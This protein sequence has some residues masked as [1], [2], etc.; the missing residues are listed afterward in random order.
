MLVAIAL[1]VLAL[2]GHAAL[3]VG[4]VNR[5]HAIGASRRLIDLVT[6]S[7]RLVLIGLP[8]L[9]IG[10]W[11]FSGKPIETWLSS[12]LDDRALRFYLAPCWI[13]ALATIW[14][15][16]E[17]RF[18]A[19]RG[20]AVETNHTEV[21]DVAARLGRKPV[22]GFRAS[23]LSRVPGN[24]VFQLAVRETQLRLPRL[25]KELDGLS[26]AHFSDLHVTGRIEIDYFHEVV[27]RV[28]ALRA[29]LIAVTGDVMDE[30]KHIDWLEETLGRLTAPLG[31]Y[32]VLGNHDQFTGRAAVVR[33]ALVEA[34]LTDLGGRWQRVEAAGATV[35]LAGSELPWLR[36]RAEMEQCPPRQEGHPHLRMLL[37]H[38]PDQF[39]WARRRDFD[40]VL[41]GHTHGGQIC[42][43]LIGP[44]HCPSW[45]GVKY[46][47]GVFF[48]SPTAMHVSR[49]VS[50]ALPIRLNC[51]PEVTKLVLRR[52]F[53]RQWTP[54][55]Q[56]I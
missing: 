9:A 53:N 46:A 8:L 16:I 32:F 54:I 6:G 25:P 52:Q 14:L 38:S 11:W 48:E 27:D 42:F 22:S 17:R 31:A 24:Q 36:L 26:I 47:S 15:W 19:R 7:C 41:A 13:V 21:V 18:D 30:M 50:S 43:P 45:H 35:I 28:L 3:W 1:A 49:G 5:I 56:R 2:L 12:A 23:M 44:I 40:L 55:A 20:A 29:D 51:R 39:G 4:A 33:K 37:A 10:H 34:G